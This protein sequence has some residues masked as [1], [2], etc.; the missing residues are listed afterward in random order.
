[1]IRCDI[2]KGKLGN[3]NLVLPL[4]D[5]QPRSD[6]GIVLDHGSSGSLSN[7]YDDLKSNALKMK[8]I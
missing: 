3:N 5:A 6:E 8:D 2:L 1:M 4:K 7:D